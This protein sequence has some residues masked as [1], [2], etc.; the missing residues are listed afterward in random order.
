MANGKNVG[1]TFTIAAFIDRLSVAHS[2]IDT[3][4]AA[5]GFI[6]S[7]FVTKNQ[8]QRIPIQP[9]VVKGFNGSKEAVKEVARTFVDIG[10]LNHRVFLYVSDGPLG[11]DMILGRPWMDEHYAVIDAKERTLTLKK[12]NVEVQEYKGPNDIK[13]ISANAFEFWRRNRKRRR[14]DVL[15]A[16]FA[17]IEKALS[18]KNHSDPAEKLPWHYHQYID[19][20][21]RMAAEKLPP[22]R[23]PNI[24]HAIDIEKHAS[25]GKEARIPWGPL[26]S[27]SRDELLVLRKSLA[28]LLDNGFIRVNH[29]PAA[30]PVLFV[31]KPGG[32]LRFCVDYQAL[33][34]ISRKNRYPLP[35][36]NETLERIGQ[37]KY[38]TKMDLISA[39]H[40]IRV[41]QGDEWKTAF[42]TRYGLFEWLVTPFGLANAPSTFQRYVNW[43]LRGYLDV[44]CSA[45]VD[46][47]LVFSDD[48]TSHRRH[49]Q[50]VLQRLGEADLR[51]D[52]DKCDFEVKETTFLGFN[53]QAGKGLQMDPRKVESIKNWEIPKSVKAVRGFLGFANFYRRFIKNFSK[54]VAPLIELTKKD[55]LF[56][57]NTEAQEAFTRLKNIFT[58]A[59]ILL[60]FHPDRETEVETDVSGHAVGGVLSQ[61]DDNGSWRPCTYF[62]KRMTPAEANYPIFDKELL[63]IVRCLEGWDHELRSVRKF[64][65]KTDHRN[66]QY[67]TAH[68]RLSER[69]MR[70]QEFLNRFNFSIQYRPGRENGAADSLSRREQDMPLNASDER[71]EGRRTC[72]LPKSIFN[73]S[74]VGDAVDFAPVV[75]NDPDTTADMALQDLWNLGR[76][77]DDQY[78]AVN[79]SIHRGDRKFPSHL[80]LKVSMSECTSEHGEILFKGRR[81]VPNFEPL[82]SRLIQDTHD[83]PLTGHPGKEATYA[84]MARSWFWPNMSGD[85]RRVVRNC[86]ACR[87]SNAWRDRRQGLLKPLPIPARI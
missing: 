41:A 8:I 15:A 30:A 18:V 50:L 20:F 42:R 43:S 51:I 85:I 59:P 7:Q 46:D 72:L 54:E 62:S 67:F 9:K 32:G 5:F 86:F 22:L 58:S 75:V 56:R 57:W 82:K 13:E 2:L 73:D 24:D 78:T 83:S 25:S 45:Y 16:S 11:Y 71:L 4:C 55:T 52:I 12:A 3:G 61:R 77:S 34:K 60:P 23:G 26:Y 87:S 63:A 29:S 40:Q 80:G 14:V 47:I 17:G 84:I 81:W 76:E 28:E 49:V 69:H 53:L 66:F 68:R 44:F 10:G 6:T 33:N 27:M 21:D 74:D 39:F 1:R 70:W 36:I 19:V 65:V 35:L 48:L 37:A 38:Y 79:K 64:T 31:K